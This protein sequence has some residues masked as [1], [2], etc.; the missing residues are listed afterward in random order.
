MDGKY[1]IRFM[2]SHPK[3]LSEEVVKTIAASD[4]LAKFIHL[5]IQ[6]GS[7]R[8]L[9]LMSRRSLILPLWTL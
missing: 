5:P 3:D 4:K 2:T 9:K 6:A 8:I 7:D 1:K